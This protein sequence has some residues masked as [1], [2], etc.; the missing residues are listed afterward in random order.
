[1]TVKDVGAANSSGSCEAFEYSEWRSYIA[2]DDG[3]PSSAF[4]SEESRALFATWQIFTPAEMFGRQVIKNVPDTLDATFQKE[5][6]RYLPFVNLREDLVQKINFYVSDETAQEVIY[7]QS[8][9]VLGDQIYAFAGKFDRNSILS[10]TL[11]IAFLASKDEFQ[12]NI[13]KSKFWEKLSKDTNLILE[14]KNNPDRRLKLDLY[15]TS[16]GQ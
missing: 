4:S 2:N 5:L 12:F 11:G 1:M 7:F 13:D 14:S 15:T 10:A 16:V 8:V 6:E 3:P 9:C